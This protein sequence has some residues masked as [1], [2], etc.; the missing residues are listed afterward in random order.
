MAEQIQ[1]IEVSIT[2]AIQG[3]LEGLGGAGRAVKQAT[4]QMQTTLNQGQGAAGGLGNALG[5][6]K[7]L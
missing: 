5:A 6:L 2:A 4:E 1:P 7:G 3:L